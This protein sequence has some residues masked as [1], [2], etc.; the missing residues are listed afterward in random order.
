METPRDEPAQGEEEGDDL[1][2]DMKI[3]GAK[4]SEIRDKK[5]VDL[6]TIPSDYINDRHTFWYFFLEI[7]L[8][9]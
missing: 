5:L 4:I 1:H 6:I 3:E 9:K 2:L 7:S 8:K